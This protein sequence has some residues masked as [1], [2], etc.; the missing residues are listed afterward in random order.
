MTSVP[1]ETSRARSWCFTLNNPDENEVLLP[2]SWPCDNYNYL[3]YQLETG[4]AGTPHLQGYI[5]FKNPVRF[6]EFRKYFIDA[7]AHVAVAKGTASQNRVYCTKEEGRLDGPWEFGILPEQGKRSDLLQVKEKM[8]DGATLKEIS[9]EHFSSFVRYHR[10]FREYKLLNTETRNWPMDV[11]VLFGPTG[12]G[13]SRHCLEQYPGAYWKSKNSGQQQ[14]WDGYLGEE[15]I[16]IDEFYGWLAW[17]YLLRLLDRYPFSLDTKHGTVQCSARTI[18]ITS[19][20]HP[21]EWYPNSKYGWDIG[22][23][24]KR[25]IISITELGATESTGELADITNS[26]GVDVGNTSAPSSA[27]VF[28]TVDAVPGTTQLSGTDIPVPRYRNGLTVQDL[29]MEK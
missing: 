11:K 12:S 20:K 9:Q 8:D 28:H 6:A 18:V 29:Y 5:S 13:K 1:S 16:I 21:R 2:Q 7:R 22:N 23:P 15:T 25:R 4:E 10:S 24:L 14:F 17:D 27:D 26:R 19:N 3:V